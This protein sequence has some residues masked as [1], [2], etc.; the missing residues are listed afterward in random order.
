M[1]VGARCSV[2][3][4]TLRSAQK[5]DSSAEPASLW[6]H[7]AIVSHALHTGS[8]KRTRIQLSAF[9]WGLTRAE[10][11]A[12]ATPQEKRQGNLKPTHCDTF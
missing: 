7:E 1:V 8:R 2:P 9:S 6:N 4:P 11:L 12:I 5:T 10:N 3:P